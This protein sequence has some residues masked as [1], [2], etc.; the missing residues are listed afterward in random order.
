MDELDK[1][2]PKPWP[3]VAAF[4]VFMLCVTTIIVAY[5]VYGG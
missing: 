1:K 2:N 5:I 3:G 4:S